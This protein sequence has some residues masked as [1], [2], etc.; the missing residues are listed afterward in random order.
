MGEQQKRE[1]RIAPQETGENWTPFNKER[2]KQEIACLEI[3]DDLILSNDK[4]G[5]HSVPPMQKVTEDNDK[6]RITAGIKSTN[7]IRRKSQEPYAEVY[8]FDDN[9]EK[10]FSNKRY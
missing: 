7:K 10:A 3:D 4:Y 2:G 6:D 5:E 1:D 9:N 8:D